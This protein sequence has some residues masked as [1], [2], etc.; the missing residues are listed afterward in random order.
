MAPPEENQLK[1]VRIRGFKSIRDQEIELNR[2]NVLIG[3]NGAGKSNLLSAVTLLQKVLNGRLGAYSMRYGTDALLYH[4][5]EETPSMAMEFVFGNGYA[6]GFELV[7]TDEGRLVFSREYY[8]DHGVQVPIS[9]GSHAEESAWKTGIHWDAASHICPILGSNNWV[10][11]NFNDTSREDAKK[12]APFLYRLRQEYPANY[13]RLTQIIQLAAPYFGD[14]CLTPQEPNQGQIC[15]RWTE[16]KSDRIFSANQLSDGLLRFICLA[17][18]LTQ[19]EE[20]CPSILVIDG[21]EIS[22]HPTAINL[23]SELVR[24]ASFT[25]QI[26][27]SIQSAAMLD[28]FDAE[29][30]LVVN[31]DG[32]GSFFSRLDP[33]DLEM[34]DDYSLGKLWRRSIIGGRLAR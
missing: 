23:V 17:V 11:Y 1:K 27:L 10:V 13:A 26:I 9:G 14:F 20:L 6:Y 3:S 34:W 16:N 8:I 18:L 24:Q 12:L 28:N 30:V 19:P 22:L 2:V 25:S 33:R 31:R 4:G 7:P 21:P 32:D 29:D 5:R 15:L